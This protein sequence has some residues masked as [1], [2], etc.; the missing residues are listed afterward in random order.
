MLASFV[1]VG[2]MIALSSCMHDG[3][4]VDALKQMLVVPRLLYRHS[5]VVAFVRLQDR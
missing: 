3:D 2:F 4:D 5:P 1:D